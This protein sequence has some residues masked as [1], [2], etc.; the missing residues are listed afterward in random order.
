[1]KR[2][3]IQKLILPHFYKFLKDKGL[4]L[5]YDQI[6]RTIRVF[7]PADK[8]VQLIKLRLPL[9][10]SLDLD[11]AEIVMYSPIKNY[12]ILVIQSG[13]ACTGLFKD[14]Q[15]INHKV[16]RAYMIRKKQGK[17]QIKHL[18]T[19][20]KSRAG[21]RVRLAET[22]EFFEEIN[23]RLQKY[24]EENRVDFIGFQVSELLQPYFFGSKIVTPFNKKD[25]RLFKIP[26]H[27]HQPT[28]ETLLSL[29]QYLL[30]AEISYH[31]GGEELWKMFLS[32]TLTTNSK[33]IDEDNW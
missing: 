17:S 23:M 15:N 20:G 28:Y 9:D 26:A 7:D 31:P 19:K 25:H 30:K 11:T 12:V 27:I 3:I 8:E 21:S 29:N 13:M 24:F 4:L 1:M 5:E 10:L 22:L 6:K 32:N 33:S 14:F 16:F 18:K 2:E